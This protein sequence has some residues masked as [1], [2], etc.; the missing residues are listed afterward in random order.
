M[1]RGG[2]VRKIHTLIAMQKIA[3]FVK[4]IKDDTARW[5]KVNWVI[6]QTS[7]KIY[8]KRGARGHDVRQEIRHRLWNLAQQKYPLLKKYMIPHEIDGASPCKVKQGNTPT[9]PRR[10]MEMHKKYYHINIP[11]LIAA[12]IIGF[13]IIFVP[14]IDRKTI[15]ENISRIL[16]YFNTGSLA[17]LLILAS[18]FLSLVIFC[19]FLLN[20]LG[21]KPNRYSKYAGYLSILYFSLLF[22]ENV[23][24]IQ[25]TNPVSVSGITFIPYWI[26]SFGVSIIGILYLL[27]FDIFGRNKKN[28]WKIFSFPII[29]V[30]TLFLIGTFMPNIVTS[31]GILITEQSKGLDYSANSKYSVG[32]IATNQNGQ[33]GF[34]IISDDGQGHYTV[35]P[36]SLDNSKKGWHTNGKVSSEIA[37]YQ[38]VEQQYP[39]RWAG[40]RMD[41]THIPNRDPTLGTSFNS[42]ITTPPTTNIPATS[43]YVT[44]QRT[45][46]TGIPINEIINRHNYYRSTVV[47]ANIPNLVWSSTLAS[48]AQSWANYLGNNN[49]FHHSTGHSENLAA[50]YSSWTSA[51][52]GWGSEKSYFI[53]APFGNSAS[54]TGNWQD[55]GHYTQIIWKTTTQCG[56]GSAPHPTYGTVYVC[57]YAPAGNIVG[58][59]PY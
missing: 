28:R 16:T 8:K 53:Y 40:G 38:S 42:V 39:I 5:Y 26:A 1:A 46:G 4:H 35:M 36:V 9:P 50:G 20:G 18:V 14:I 57:H 3:Y 17:D 19:L 25:N 59:Y 41:I 7:H 32:E 24:I 6:V 47:G 29:C 51:I 12:I 56:C 13:F 2:G 30:I 44:T 15:Y 48:S 10:P 22:M 37:S 54:N 43:I 23:F 31:T 49:L 58:Y 55:V 45:T 33:E 52:D 34:A 11:A 21:I 27:L